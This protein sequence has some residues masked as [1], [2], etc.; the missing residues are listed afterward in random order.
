LLDNSIARTKKKRQQVKQYLKNLNC[1]KVGEG[2]GRFE[3]F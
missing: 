1:I 2:E 3:S